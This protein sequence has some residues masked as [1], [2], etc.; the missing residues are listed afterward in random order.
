MVSRF[1][2]VEKV[3]RLHREFLGSVSGCP[4]GGWCRGVLTCSIARAPVR[5]HSPDRWRR[6]R[7]SASHQG[8]FPVGEDDQ[9]FR[10]P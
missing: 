4:P 3:D 8:Q 1:V 10:P 5:R 2:A 9:L 7:I 6:G